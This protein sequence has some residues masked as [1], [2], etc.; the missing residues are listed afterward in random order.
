[1]ITIGVDIGGTSMKAALTEPGGTVYAKTRRP[2]LADREQDATID[3]LHGCIEELLDRAEAE[4]LG[5]DGIGIG[6]PGAIDIASGTVFHP[7][8]L[9]A[10]REVPLADIMHDRWKRE[11]RIDNDANCAALGEAHFG[12]GREYDDF[13]GL[14]LGTGVGSG[15]IFGNRIYHGE[16]GFAGEFGHITIDFNGPPCNCGN[17]GCVEAYVG[18]GYMMRAATP[19]LRNASGSPLHERARQNPESLSPEDL[20]RAAAEGDGVSA[21]ILRTAGDRLGVAIASTANLLDMTTF[22]IGG[23]ISGAGDVL[24]DG[25]RSSAK[26]RALKVHRDRLVILPAALGNDAGMLGAAALLV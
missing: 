8:N 4:S 7:P 22:I 24:F 15:I 19:L 17:N 5:V 23:G 9:P 6:V 16:R 14:T 2:T 26:A 18:I 3:Q 10:W 13:I 11:V 20:A 21:D 25:I 12:A 1:M